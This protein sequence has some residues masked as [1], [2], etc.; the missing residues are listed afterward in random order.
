MKMPRGVGLGVF[1]L[2][3]FSFCLAMFLQ[4]NKSAWNHELVPKKEDFTGNWTVHSK[5][6]GDI[7]LQVMY[8]DGK[9][10]GKETSWYKY[11]DIVQTEQFYS[12]G[13]L[14]GAC[15]RYDRIAGSPPLLRG[16]FLRG[17][18]WSG[19]FLTNFNGEIISSPFTAL[20]MPDV[21]WAAVRFDNG[22]KVERGIIGPK[23]FVGGPGN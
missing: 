11:P 21:V 18:P 14:D 1:A 5:Q 20:D 2:L 16:V 19:I 8:K 23:G 7:I 15:L 12:N 6:T 17:N 10:D 3:L 4:V 22:V 9:K 13:V